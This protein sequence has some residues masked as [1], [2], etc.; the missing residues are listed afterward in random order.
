MTDISKAIDALKKSSIESFEINNI[1][2]IPVAEPEDI[3]PI[4]TKVRRIFKEIDFQKTWQID[5]YYYSRHQ[6]LTS[7]MY[8][9][10]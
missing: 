3:Y 9:N 4:A 1:L 7:E 10:A 8:P 5:P 6:S 2:V